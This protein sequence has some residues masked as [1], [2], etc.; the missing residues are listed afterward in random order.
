MQRALA[1]TVF[2]ISRFSQAREFGRQRLDN[3]SPVRP[4][5]FGFLRVIAEYITPPPFAL[6][7]DH[8]LH[9]EIVGHSLIA[10]PMCHDLLG[11]LI[12]TTH[13]HTQEIFTPG[14][15]KRFGAETIPA[16]PTNK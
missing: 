4:L 14:T 15:R 10:T 1:P 13:R 12:T 8:F 11:D 2:I 6:A 5:P 9:L 16:S 7:Y 3:L